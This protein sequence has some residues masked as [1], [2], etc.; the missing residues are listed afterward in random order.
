MIARSVVVA[1]AVATEL[2]GDAALGHAE[3]DALK[4]MRPAE[5]HVNVNGENRLHGRQ[6]GAHSGS[7]R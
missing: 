6:H 2:V 3:R 5:V 7:P 1:D 4:H